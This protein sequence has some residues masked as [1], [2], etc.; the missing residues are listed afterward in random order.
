MKVLL[1]FIA[2]FFLIVFIT[3]HWQTM[4][5]ILLWVVIAAFFIPMTYEGFK[6]VREYRADMRKVK[7]DYFKGLDERTNLQHQ[8]YLAGRDEGVYGDYPPAKLD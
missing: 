8:Q 2:A 3:N 6:F 1:G 7:A 5:W 4:L